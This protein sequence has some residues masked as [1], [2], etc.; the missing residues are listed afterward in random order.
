MGIYHGTLALGNQA[1]PGNVIAEAQLVPYP[2]SGEG[3]DDDGIGGSR[4]GNVARSS[5]LSMAITEFHFLLLFTGRLQ[6]VSRLNGAVVQEENLETQ[7]LS[8]GHVLTLLTDPY[9]GGGAMQGAAP[10]LG[11]ANRLWLFTDRLPFKVR[12]SHEERDVWML[13][14]EK[15]VAGEE[16]HFDSAAQHCKTAVERAQ[17]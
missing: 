8:M 9:T 2:E 10:G 15:A 7:D 5:P 16:V 12:V 17:V 6:V 4:R 14:L 3:G 13:F 1:T 11:V